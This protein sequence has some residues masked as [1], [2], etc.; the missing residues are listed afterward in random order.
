[1]SCSQ[2]SEE[3]LNL[4]RTFMPFSVSIKMEEDENEEEND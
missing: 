4:K 1:M 2:G 3:I